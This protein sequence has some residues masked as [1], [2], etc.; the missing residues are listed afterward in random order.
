ML[1][2]I[3][4]GLSEIES[5]Q[6]FKRTPP[7]HDP[8]FILSFFSNADKHRVISEYYPILGPMEGGIAPKDGMVRQQAF[9][10]PQQW[11]PNHE[12][13]IARVWYASPGPAEVRFEGKLS[14]Q[15]HFAAPAFGKHSKGFAVATS[16]FKEV[17]DHVAMIVDKFKAL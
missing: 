10:P 5:L 15:I 3:T 14:V 12:M 7:Q 8:L 11:R 17:S 4:Q 1:A 13:I 9:A 2:G 16:T 6:P